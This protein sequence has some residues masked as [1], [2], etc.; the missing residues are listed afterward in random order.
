MG[1]GGAG[2]GVPGPAAGVCWPAVLSS[3]SSPGRGGRLLHAGARDSAAQGAQAEPA[4][5]GRPRLPELQVPALLT[6]PCPPRA[7]LLLRQPH[8]PGPGGA[9]CW[10]EVQ[11][12]QGGGRKEMPPEP[13]QPRV[14]GQ[15][16][17]RPPRTLCTDCRGL[18]PPAPQPGYSTSQ[19][20]PG[21]S[22]TGSV[23][24]NYLMVFT[25]ASG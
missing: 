22:G 24:V 15:S 2:Q 16:D 23:A 19:P 9:G 5:R 11:T 3:P 4:G 18:M 25:L 10:E 20:H 12:E 17:R 7:L 8:R 14:S 13:G 6:P 21:P 1:A